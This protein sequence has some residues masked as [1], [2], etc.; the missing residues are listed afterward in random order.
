MSLDKSKFY[1]VRS[2]DTYTDQAHYTDRLGRQR[3]T[4]P[5]YRAQRELEEARKLAEESVE[6]D[7]KPL[8]VYEV[9]LIGTMGVRKAEWQP[10]IHI[11]D[12][13]LSFTHNIIDDFKRHPNGL[14]RGY[15]EY[16]HDESGRLVCKHPTCPGHLPGGGICEHGIGLKTWK[17]L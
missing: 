3:M 16:V 12:L 14:L 4:T 17:Q 11:R 1:I 9:R 15:E 8:N 7:G 5:V 10:V 6:K 2:P 13:R